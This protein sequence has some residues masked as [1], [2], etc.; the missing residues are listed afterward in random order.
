MV[1]ACVV[2]KDKSPKS[3]GIDADCW[4]NVDKDGVNKLS[5]ATT[6]GANGIGKIIIVGKSLCSSA[7]EGK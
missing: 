2:S 5:A 1:E 6:A 4:S 3:A 7:L